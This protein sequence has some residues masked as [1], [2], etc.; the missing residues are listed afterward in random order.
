[1]I[2]SP[3]E[4]A[5][6]TAQN[7]RIIAPDKLAEIQALYDRGLYLQAHRA[8]L[9]FGD[10]RHWSGTQ[11]RLLAGR[12]ATN[13]GGHQLCHI[14]H[15]L[16]WRE[17][18]TDPDLI[19][20]RCH[21]IL[22]RRGPLAAYEFLERFPAV[23]SS[24]HE[25]RL[26]WL[27]TRASVAAQFRDFNAAENFL[28]EAARLGPGSPWLATSRAHVLE[29]EDRYLEAL[30]AA[31]H[32]LS[33]RPWYRP[34]IQ[35]VAHV[36]QLLDR[37]REALEL[38]TEAVQ[39]IESL[40]VVRQLA[41]LQQELGQHEA[42]LASLSRLEELAPLI[43]E[44]VR[45][46]LQRQRVTL[47]CLCRDLPSALALAKQIT[48]PYYTDL[49]QRIET[50]AARRLVRLEV[51]F[52]RQH[53]LTCAPATL[54][55][56]SRYWQ[57]PAEH[58]E[59][60]EEICYDGTPAHSERH[61]AQSHGWA[62]REFTV[63]WEAAI[64][65]LDRKVPFTLT[66]SETTNAHL[67]AIFGY[68]ELR[69][70]LWVRDPF[71]YSA[72][73]FLV[74]RLLEAHR[75][76]GPRGM[77][78]VPLEQ[79]QLLENIALPDAELYDQL[80]AVERALAEHHRP[81][82]LTLCL[83]M[84]A[85]SPEHRLTLTARRAIAAYDANTPVM[86]ECLELLLK[87]FPDDGNLNLC[88]LGCLRELA[89]RGER[90]VVLEKLSTSRGTD[91]VFWQHYAAELR[92]DAREHRAAASWIR[93][94]LRYRPAD[95]ALL[96]AWA[97]LLWDQRELTKANHFYR[98]AACL[99]DK[100]EQ[101]ARS[102]FIA[103]R[104]LGNTESGL[105]FLKGR[106]ERLGL[107]SSN[108]SITLAES[109]QHLD[110]E[111][112]AFSFVDQALAR[113]PADGSIRLFASDFHG[114]FARFAAAEKLLQ[115][116]RELCSPKGWHRSAATLAGYQNQ[117]SVALQH[118]RD[119]LALDPMSYEACGAITTLL[120]ETEGREAALAFL[121]ERCEQFPFSC[122]LLALRINWLKEDGNE[123]VIPFLRQLLEV[124]PAG[125]WTWR[126]L[127]I[128]LTA[129][130]D[131]DQALAAAN[132]AIRLEPNES[133]CY[134]TRG[135][136]LLSGGKFE[137]AR[138]DFRQSLLLEVDN[139]FALNHYVSTAA[140][141]AA[142]K[143]ALEFVAGE[144]RRQVIFHEALSAFQQAARG[145]L[146]DQEVLTLLREA[147]RARPDLWQAWSVLVNQLIDSGQHDEAYLLANQA[148]ERFPL[149]PILWV[150]LARVARARLDLANEISALEKALEI[151][152]GYAY[153][154]RELADAYDRKHDFPRARAILESAVAVNPLDPYNHGCL[155][156]LL[157][158]IGERDAAL[159]RVQHAL[160]LCPGYEWAWKVLKHWGAE[161]SKPALA[162]DT[163]RELS[164]LRAGEARSW[165]MLAGSL[166]PETDEKEIFAAL[167]RAVALNPQCEDAYDLRA[168]RLAELNRFDEALAQCEAF[169]VKPTPAILQLRAAWIEA[170]RGNLSVSISRAQ[171]ALEEY[172]D[173]YRGWQMLS[174]WC[175][176]NEDADTA[177]KAAEKMAALA[178][179]QPV[180]LGYL[181][182]LKLRLRDRE[183]ARAAF[184]RAFTLDPNYHY[185]GVSL[186]QID[187]KDGKLNEAEQTLKVLSRHGKDDQS[188]SCA[189]QLA[190]ARREWASGLD[191]LNQLCATNKLQESSLER[192]VDVLN[193]KYRLQKLTHIL[194]KH[195]SEAST[196]PVVAEVWVRLQVRRGN[197]ALRKRLHRLGVAGELRR[198]AILAYLGC[199]GDALQDARQK[200]DVTKPWTLRF[201]LRRLLK[202]NRE[203]LR[204]D[205]DGWGKVGYVLA[206][207][208]KPD[209]VIDW[210]KDWKTRPNAESWMLNNL[211]LMLQRKHRYAESRE[212]V[213]HAVS[214]RHSEHLFANFRIWAAFEEA[215]D[216][217][218]TL[219]AQHISSLPGTLK[220]HL[221]PL[222]A[223]AELLILRG[224]T[225]GEK[226]PAFFKKV[227]SRLKKSFGK[228]LP[229]Q[230]EPYVQNAYKR[231][232]RRLSNEPAPLAFRLWSTWFYWGGV[233]I[234][235]A[236]TPLAILT[237]VLAQKYLAR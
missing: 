34:G 235:I 202:Q 60:A 65:L 15:W 40:Y 87:H 123:V 119:V 226:P 212:V 160:R 77:A 83:Q 75:S 117:K 110:R 199:I 185:A 62:V 166:S 220:E 82:A 218:L 56:I 72:G 51:P 18:K 131:K 169:P 149:L 74:E 27:T 68:D 31:R 91:P 4:G 171:S 228:R 41:A 48:E 182:D 124:N 44:D 143:E 125:C 197:W 142:R 127:A 222:R 30:E 181:G 237:L 174:E 170:Q 33:L 32:A 152:P 227:R 183:G 129:A 102:Y 146:S 35:A 168:R 78:L 191:L 109:L 205:T 108:P 176:Q 11:A 200:R 26:H 157:W 163:A 159:S 28:N 43:Q 139:Q 148:S 84:Q 42:A 189:I 92:A 236:L 173:H 126:E 188:L 120:A 215:L 192:A 53:H 186:F 161:A 81:E 137:E 89:R 198:C 231:F 217:N 19:A 23:E 194:E 98:L 64:G 187:V 214:L 147:H 207:I 3:S 172:P 211:V 229:N 7:G 59:V 179:L 196:S 114:R 90:L 69:K 1:M 58:L 85:G 12:L 106:H 10:Y 20:Y 105:E 190:A 121:H 45:Q 115:E 16:A 210:L 36:L 107:K 221:E 175:L 140:T 224:K 13:L 104:H 86:L 88:K 37:H 29:V 63:T 180:P 225:P 2:A 165:L 167:D 156:S 135:H 118:W 73:E 79:K 155:G 132:E 133:A 71:V 55:A 145:V 38:L 25:A 128:V 141:L 195:L 94:A 201:H 230:T 213:R 21:S 95:P 209:A 232:C 57:R 233:N 206:C 93:W 6:R 203:W 184:Q 14:L 144:L 153:A 47:H 61:W 164:R 208:G 122:P 101:Y 103:S 8:S 52:V 223:M 216:D 96:A 9:P 136:V 234:A 112:E 158:S 50:N 116:A 97:D 100:Q 219:A 204:K 162:A 134:S 150:D 22:E 46:W 151:N 99:A 177:V 24:D 5:C 66:T 193:Q 80:H 130:G 76:T 49:T 178:P 70:T 67:Q 154:S 17:N 54:S 111:P 113:R 138:A 39:H